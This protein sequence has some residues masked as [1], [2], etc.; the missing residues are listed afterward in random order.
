MD[1]PRCQISILPLPPF[2]HREVVLGERALRLACRW[3]TRDEAL[4]PLTINC[5][6]SV[7]GGESYVNIE[8]DS[9]ATFDL[10]NVVIAI[11]LPGLSHAP[12]VAQVSS[13]PSSAGTESLWRQHPP[14]PM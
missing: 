6:P 13:H 3:Q 14:F 10:Q 8:Y 7:S 12:R 1:R 11:P 2:Y 9:T 4:V 5:W